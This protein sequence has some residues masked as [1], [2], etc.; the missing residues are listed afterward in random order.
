M[1]CKVCKQITTGGNSIFCKNC[2]GGIHKRCGKWYT[3]TTKNKCG[4]FC[5]SCIDEQEG[6]LSTVVTIENGKISR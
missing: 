3:S 6:L 1:L 5:P 2:S 4:F